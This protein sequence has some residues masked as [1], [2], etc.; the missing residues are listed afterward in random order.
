MLGGVQVD[1]G[2]GL[3]Y[4]R[5]VAVSAQISTK[6]TPLMSGQ[7]MVFL[8]PLGGNSRP[9]IKGTFPVETIR[10]ED[11]ILISNRFLKY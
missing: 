4:Q 10:C 11:I 5:M 2:D 9:F 1:G 7:G 3:K 8:E 6:A